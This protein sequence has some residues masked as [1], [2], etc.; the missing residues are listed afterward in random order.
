MAG[1]GADDAVLFANV[2]RA[3]GE[4]E[5]ARPDYKPLRLKTAGVD[6]KA[7]TAGDVRLEKWS[8]GMIRD[9]ERELFQKIAAEKKAPAVES[10]ILV[11]DGAWQSAKIYLERVAGEDGESGWY[12]GKT[13]AAAAAKNL[14]M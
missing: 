6:H 13:E 8:D 1:G 10:T 5:P 11:E 7:A 14:S 2:A 9:Q 3:M 4:M 12:L